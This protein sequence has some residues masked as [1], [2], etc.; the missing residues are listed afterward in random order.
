M[1]DACRR[2]GRVNAQPP[3]FLKAVELEIHMEPVAEEDLIAAIHAKHAH[4]RDS[5]PTKVFV[6]VAIIFMIVIPFAGWFL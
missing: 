1:T 3:P 2:L 6:G 5:W 4:E